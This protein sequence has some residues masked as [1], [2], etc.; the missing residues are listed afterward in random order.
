LLHSVIE[1]LAFLQLHLDDTIGAYF[2]YGNHTEK[3]S[4]ALHLIFGTLF[5]THGY[6]L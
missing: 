5:A 3:V 4:A 2:D 1:L 6:Q